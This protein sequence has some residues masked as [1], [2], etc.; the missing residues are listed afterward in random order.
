MIYVSKKLES[1]EF[2]HKGHEEKH[3]GHE[4]FRELAFF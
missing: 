1:K 3:E 2:Y 4:G